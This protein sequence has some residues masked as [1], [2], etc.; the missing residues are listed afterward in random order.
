[1]DEVGKGGGTVLCYSYQSEYMLSCHTM[2]LTHWCRAIA[3]CCGCLSAMGLDSHCCPYRSF[4]CKYSKAASLAQNVAFLREMLQELGRGHKVVV[5]VLDEF[6]LFAKKAKQ[7]TLYNLLDALQSAGMQVKALKHCRCKCLCVTL[8][9]QHWKLHPSKADVR[10]CMNQFVLH[11]CLVSA[12]KK[13]Q[14]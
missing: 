8:H 14:H 2:H 4:N 6:D 3:R 10:A 11:R 5:F 9:L 1:M 13:H 7:T 12:A